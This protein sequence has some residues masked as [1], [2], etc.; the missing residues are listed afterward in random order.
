MDTKELLL[1]KNVLQFYS[2]MFPSLLSH[3]D[4]D[5]DNSR[6]Q[7]GESTTVQYNFLNDSGELFQFKEGCIVVKRSHVS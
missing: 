6:N 5:S 4:M 1:E 3:S 7:E 2:V